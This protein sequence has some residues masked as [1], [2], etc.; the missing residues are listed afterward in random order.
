VEQH[1]SPNRCCLRMG[2]ARVCPS[3][4]LCLRGARL[5]CRRRMATTAAAGAAPAAPSQKVVVWFRTDLRVHDNALLQ[6]AAGISVAAVLP[7]YVHSPQQ[8]GACRL[9]PDTPRCGRHRA[10]FLADALADLRAR[11]RRSGSGLAVLVGQPEEVLPRLRA[12]V[13]LAHAQFTTEERGTE[14]RVAAALKAV[15]AEL[16]LLPFDSLYAAD[17]LPFAPDLRDLPASGMTFLKRV[18]AVTSPAPPADAAA[19]GVLRRL[20]LGAAW[21]QHAA[22]DAPCDPAALGLCAALPPR[23]EHSGGGETG[24]LTLLAAYLSSHAVRDYAETRNELCGGS[25]LSRHLAHGCL[26][27]RHVAAELARYDAQHP[28]AAASTGGAPGGLLFELGVRDFF[29]FSARRHGAAL[30]AEQGPVPRQPPHAWCADASVL[31]AWRR[32]A[33]GV[34]LVDAIQRQLLH[35]GHISNRARQV[36]ASWAVL[37]RA[38]DWRACA[39]HFEANLSDYDPASNAGNW[40]SVAGLAGGRENWF[41]VALAASKYDADGRFVRR[42]VPELALLPTE[43]IHAPWRLSAAELHACGVQ[44]GVTYPRANL[45]QLRAP[46]PRAKTHKKT[47]GV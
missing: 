28:G 41:D 13:V 5:A 21:E 30:F 32:G 15:G 33:T 36:T 22:L 10:R 16:R 35:Q 11:L 43:H 29:R 46:P 31:D 8:W 6:H 17:A 40:L 18:Q 24:G 38:L 27:P 44:L 42:W 2:A 39:E 1:A 47:A 26:S 20:Q 45:T 37:A 23:D 7:A 25:L 4:A 19:D 34:P 14:A 3:R 9:L 12:D